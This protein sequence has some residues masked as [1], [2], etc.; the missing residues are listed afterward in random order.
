MSSPPKDHKFLWSLAFYESGRP[1]TPI[2]D[3]GWTGTY[4]PPDGQKTMF[5]LDYTG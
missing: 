2:W 5:F 1:V 3:K 4:L